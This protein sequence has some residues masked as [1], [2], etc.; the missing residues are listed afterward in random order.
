QVP[1][2]LTLG[3]ESLVVE[4]P[5]PG[6]DPAPLDRVAIGVGADRRKKVEVRSPSR[7]VAGRFRAPFV[8]RVEPAGPLPP[9]PVV[10]DGALDLV[11]RRRRA[12]Q[13]SAVHA[14]TLF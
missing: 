14:P 6:L 2:A 11:R 9:R 3:R 5:A 13:E 8:A 7:P 1:P 10:V 4:P 12:P